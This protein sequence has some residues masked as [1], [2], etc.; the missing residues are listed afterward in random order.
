MTH[1]ELIWILKRPEVW[2]SLAAPAVGLFYGIGEIIGLW[3][4]LFGRDLAFSGVRR[5]QVATGYTSRLVQ[6]HL[7]ALLV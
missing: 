3:D 1:R 5:I 2:L 6:E 4:H 7:C